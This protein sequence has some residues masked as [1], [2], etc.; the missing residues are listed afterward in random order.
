MCIWLYYTSPKVIWLQQFSRAL[1]H[2]PPKYISMCIWGWKVESMVF[3]LYPSVASKWLVLIKNPCL[4][5]LLPFELT[6]LHL[7][8]CNED[9]ESS[10]AP[11]SVFH[12]M[13]CHYPERLQHPFVYLF[14]TLASC[15]FFDL[16]VSIDFH[17]YSSSILWSHI[18]TVMCST[19]KISSEGQKSKLC[20]IGL[21]SRCQQG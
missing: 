6:I 9:I 16:L 13:S 3:L 17:L 18:H 12:P 1:S 7:T 10:C 15:L 14:H 2:S 11:D 5:K 4:L 8:L 19:F 21:K 20:I